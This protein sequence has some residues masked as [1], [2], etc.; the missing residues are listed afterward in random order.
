MKSKESFSRDMSQVYV[1]TQQTG[2]SFCGILLV[3]NY[4]AKLHLSF[5]IQRTI[6]ELYL[7]YD[8]AI[9]QLITSCLKNRMTTRFI[10]LWRKRVMS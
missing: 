9:I 1:L 8:V 5:L 10:T 2:A 7:A 6:L 4:L 3:K